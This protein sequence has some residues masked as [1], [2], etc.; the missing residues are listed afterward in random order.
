MKTYNRALDC[1]AIA[2]DQYAKGRVVTAAAAFAKAMTQPDVK[3][4]LG[5]L[6]AS[7]K[8]AFEA[9]AKT[10]A[11]A[12]PKLTVEAKAEIL[13]LANLFGDNPELNA[14]AIVAEAEPEG[15]PPMVEDEAVEEEDK[16][17]KGNPFAAALASLQKQTKVKK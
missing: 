7:N 9:K 8:Q 2:V 5:I 14:S 10:Q 13:Q 15:E 11:S 3:Q 1:L 12:K 6:E 4:A 17:D 16:E